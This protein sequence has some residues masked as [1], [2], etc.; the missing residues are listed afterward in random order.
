MSSRLLAC[1][2]GAACMLTANA[3]L[4]APAGKSRNYDHTV[5]TVDPI[6]RMFGYSSS[7]VG[8]ST[9]HIHELESK[10]YPHQDLFKL[11]VDSGYVGSVDRVTF[12]DGAIEAIAELNAAGIPV[13]VV[14]NQA[15]VARGHF[16]LEDVHRVHAYIDAELARRRA[17]EAGLPPDAEPYLPLRQAPR[18]PVDADAPES[19]PEPTDQSGAQ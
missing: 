13:A 4:A 1:L 6:G 12:I 5:Q 3:V 8:R 2:A 11:L 9:V 18:G 16:T 10:E 15:G 7:P 19:Q 14:T 17:I